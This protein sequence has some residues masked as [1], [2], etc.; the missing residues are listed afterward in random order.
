MTRNRSSAGDPARTLALLWRTPEGAPRR[1]PRRGLDLAEVVTT[2]VTL[3]DEHGV[4]AVTMR[5]LADRAGVGTMSLYTYVSDRDQLLDLMLDTVYAA[6]PRRD[7]A[8]RPWRE[9]AGSVA[10]ENRELF[11]A[12]P[13]AAEISTLRPPL[14][15]GQMAKYEHELAAFDGC[16]LDDVAVD[17]CLTLL[18]SFVRASARDAHDARERQRHE[19]S[20]DEQ[21]WAA[22]GPLL[23]GVLDERRFPR[24][25]R[26]GTAAG[27]AHGSAHDPDHAYAFGLQRLL[28]GLAALVEPAPRL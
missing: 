8:A 18:L 12:H 10:E 22:A 25:V 28:D 23:A 4:E 24:A 14:G 20:T 17:D 1:G 27:I 7:V 19:P 21:W 2:A 5:R 9:R 16:G 11:R 13:W 3:A 15:P 26:I 6:M